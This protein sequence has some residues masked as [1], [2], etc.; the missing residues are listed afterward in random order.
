M[1]DNIA[2]VPTPGVDS[3]GEIAAPTA[4]MDAASVQDM[5]LLGMFL[6]AGPVVK[7]IML[8]LLLASFWCW[9]IIFD[10]LIRLK[11]L[12]IKTAK[13]E[14]DFWSG[15]ML[16]NLFNRVKTAADH[17]MAMIFVA[18]MNEWQESQKTRAEASSSKDFSLKV[19]IKERI[20]QAMSVARNRELDKLERNLGVLATVGSNAPFVGLFGTVWGIMTSFHSIALMKNT[21]LA[22]VAPGIAEALL[23]TA[24]GLFAAIPAAIFY[25]KFTNDLTRFSNTLDGFSEEFSAIISRELDER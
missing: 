24:I 9:A 16:E 25:N 12:K 19:G 13:F 15:D 5:S 23:A 8:V 10:K 1:A 6:Q 14:R 21:S 7:I 11:A 2:A 20:F 22:V 4:L 18:G 17:P 3:G